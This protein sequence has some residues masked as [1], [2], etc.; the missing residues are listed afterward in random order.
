MDGLHSYKDV[1]VIGATHKLDLIELV[2]LRPGRFDKI[3][4]FPLP[5]YNSRIMI[6][7][8]HTR[9]LELDIDVSLEDIAK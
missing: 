9:N 6:F 5:D 4:H 7:E 8:I 1:I 3:I 2:L